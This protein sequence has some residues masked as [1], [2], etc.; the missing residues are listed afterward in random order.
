MKGIS[1]IVSAVIVLAVGITA[2]SIY[3]EWAPYLAENIAGDAAEQT[4]QE[5]KCRNA[6]ITV[7]NAEY[8]QSGQ[9]AFFDL[10]NTGTIRLSD[11]LNVGALT[12]S[13][14]LNRTTVSSLDVGETQHITI[15]TDRTPERLMVSSIDCPEIKAET[16][17]IDID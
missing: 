4:D 11:G 5:I 9:I 10:E 17:R 3:A 14:V 15:R 16:E 1:H 7:E 12:S 13:T 6:A 8:S 2:V